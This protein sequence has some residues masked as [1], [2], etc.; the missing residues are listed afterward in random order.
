[1][2]LYRSVGDAGL[3]SLGRVLADSEARLSEAEIGSLLR[4]TRL[5]DPFPGGTARYRLLESFRAVQRED[6]CANRILAFIEAAVEPS[7]VP[8]PDRRALRMAEVN[9][10][11]AGDGYAVR[12]DGTAGPMEP[13]PGQ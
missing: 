5:P 8:D 9:R 7:S 4:A 3:E 1:M 10:A 13:S 6:L 11:L 12:S 2:P